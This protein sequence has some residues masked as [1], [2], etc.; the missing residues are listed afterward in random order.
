MQNVKNVTRMT[1][2]HSNKVRHSF[3][4]EL[5]IPEKRKWTVT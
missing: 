5:F 3:L 4:Y 1:V 2:K